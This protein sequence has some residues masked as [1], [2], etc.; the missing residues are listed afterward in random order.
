MDQ[1]ESFGPII[2]GG[3][4]L[5]KGKCHTL[6]QVRIEDILGKGRKKGKGG[7]VGGEEMNIKEIPLSRDRNGTFIYKPE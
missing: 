2:K 6:V 3:R 1:T 5:G 4:G 7:L